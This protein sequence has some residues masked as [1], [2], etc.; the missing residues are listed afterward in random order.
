V[1][2]AGNRLGQVLVPLAAGSL[3]AALGVGAIFVACGLVLLSS[4]TT[5]YNA[6]RPDAE[7][8]DAQ[9]SPA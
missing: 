9:T 4:A 1:R 3:A 2:L 5:T 8:G 7:P 6:T